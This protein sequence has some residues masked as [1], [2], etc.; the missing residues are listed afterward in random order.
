[1][2]ETT[3]YKQQVFPL[4]AFLAVLVVVTLTLFTVLFKQSAIETDLLQRSRQ[5][6]IE[7]GFSSTGLQFKGR[8]GVLSGTV[9]SEEEAGEMLTITEQVDGVRAVENL[10]V[11]ATSSTG[12]AQSQL[13]LDTPTPTR[14]GLHVPAREYEIEQID[15]SGIRFA[16]AKADLNPDQVA[17]LQDVVAYLRQHPDMVIEVSAHTDSK[18]GTALGNMAVTQARAD[19]IRNYLLSQGVNAAQVVAQGYGSVRPVAD[20]E[21]DDG[22]EKN[23]RIEI[24]VL[25]E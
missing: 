15:L 22:R 21:T 13:P 19:A 24:T 20:N 6:L 5:A 3:Q 11:V 23:R 18:N 25:K 9:A 1:M 12:V 2:A 17:P 7:A 14:T 10:L 16:Y 4:M 8:D